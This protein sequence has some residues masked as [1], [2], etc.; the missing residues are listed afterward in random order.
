MMKMEKKKKAKIRLEREAG[1]LAKL[2]QNGVL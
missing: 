2:I 1:N